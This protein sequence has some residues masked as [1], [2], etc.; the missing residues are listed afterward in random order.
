MSSLETLN[1]AGYRNG[2][3]P[4][5]FFRQERETR[6]VAIL[7]PGAGYT[8]HMPVVYYPGRLL[9]A[10]GA[11]V[12][13]VEYAYNK[14]PDFQALSD[15]EQYRW[16]YTDV[17]AAYDAALSQRD[18]AR[19]TLVGKSIGTLAMG[20]LLTSG[21][22]LPEVQCVWLTPLLRNEELIRQIKQV[23]HRALFVIGTADRVYDA[24]KLAEVQQATAGDALV[25]EGADHS[26]EIVGDV[27]QSVRALL[28]IMQRMQK[29]LG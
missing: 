23:K 27:L 6:H 11:D 13:R 9:V 16:L 29:F 24:T 5:T 25:I 18:Y 22:P 2:A 28:E 7:F 3:I 21:K 8:A 12:L 1:I 20:H 14:R 19:V 17:S 15:A 4:N 26:L 10:Q